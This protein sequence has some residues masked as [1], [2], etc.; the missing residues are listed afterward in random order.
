MKKYLRP[1]LLVLLGAFVLIQLFQIDKSN[2]PIDPAQD[3]LSMANPPT[4]IAT[5]VRQACYDCHSHST[6]YP[7][8]AWVQPAGWWLQNHVQ[9]G[10]EHLNFAVWTTYPAKRAAHKL[11]ECYEVVE[12]AEMPM[13]SYTWMHAEA[14]LSDAQRTQLVGWFRSEYQ[15]AEAVEAGSPYMPTSSE[16]TEGEEEGYEAYE[17]GEAHY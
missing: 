14:R 2:P 12:S 17:K 13:Q 9:E 16:K 8:Y 11:E 7:W 6:T 5:L 4:E 10:R 15:K 1:A 3:Y